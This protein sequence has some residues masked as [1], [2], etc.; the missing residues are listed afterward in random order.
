MNHTVYGL[1][2]KNIDQILQSSAHGQSRMQD[3]QL[4]GELSRAK[5]G[6]GRLKKRTKQSILTLGTRRPEFGPKHLMVLI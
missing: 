3:M 1:V 2:L 5:T 4:S 6:Q